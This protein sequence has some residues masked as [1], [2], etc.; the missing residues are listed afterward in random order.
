M[1]KTPTSDLTPEQRL[2]QVAIILARGVLRYKRSSCVISPPEKEVAE[3]SPT[4][5]E[6][7]Q[8]L[9]LSGSRR[10]GI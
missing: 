7:P 3:S 6:V 9:R 8:N 10:I 4:G 2:T 1:V 5:L